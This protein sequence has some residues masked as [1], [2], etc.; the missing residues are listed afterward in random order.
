[1]LF[2]LVIIIMVVGIILA[3]IGYHACCDVIEG[4]GVITSVISFIVAVIMLICIVGNH[5]GVDAN[6][7]SNQELYRALTYKLESGAC[8]DEFGLLNKSV[9][10]EMQDWNT[11]V[12]KYQ[13]LQD[14]FWL[15][16][17]YP[18]IYDQFEI[19]D[20]ENFNTK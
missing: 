19:I 3:T 9:I 18:N 16:I 1:M 14:D 12:V 8:R 17:F 11:D 7:A 20:Y 15:G 4:T 6:V 2:W 5:C 10:D 13:S